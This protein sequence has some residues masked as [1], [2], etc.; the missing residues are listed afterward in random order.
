M[1]RNIANIINF[2][3]SSINS[4]N[5]TFD[6]FFPFWGTKDFF[7]KI[8][9]YHTQSHEF[10]TP[11]QNSEKKTMIHFQDAGADGQMDG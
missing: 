4:K 1:S 3:Y 9:L 2:H 8:W 10:L 7:Q 11:C 5:P 6:T